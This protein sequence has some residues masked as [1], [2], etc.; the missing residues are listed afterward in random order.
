MLADPRPVVLVTQ[1]TIATD[2]R[3]LLQP[4]LHAL[5]DEPVQVIAV[6]GGPDPADLPAPPPN[7]RV[8][9]Y[10]P[11]AAL[12]P[13]VSAFVTNG[14]YGGLHFAL[15]HGVPIVV[16]G[17][18]EEKPELVA[19]VNWS[20]VGHR[21]AHAVSR[22]RSSCARRCGGCST[23]RASPDPRR[24]DAGR[25]GRLPR[26][27]PC[28]RA[29]RGPGRRQD[30]RADLIAVHEHVVERG[31]QADR[32]RAGQHRRVAEAR[33]LD[34]RRVRAVRG[35]Q[36]RGSAPAAGRR[37]APMPPPMTTSATSA[38]AAIGTM[39]AAIRRASSSTTARASS[40]PAR[41]APKIARTSYGGVSEVAAAP[42][43]RAARRS[44][45][46]ADRR[47]VV[48][49]LELAAERVV[50]LAGRAVVAAVQLAA[51]HEP[52]S[53]GRCRSTGTRSPP[54]PRRRRASAR[55]R[56]RG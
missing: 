38:T 42:R 53:R 46:D 10:V 50:D 33:D 32:Q 3:D 14:G 27:R 45:D 43:P 16:A 15:A 37:S 49:A 19:R 12:M 31:A 11:F 52:G 8:E 23:S 36:R 2:P 5:A 29:R 54:R 48:L 24:R 44:A 56:P 1:G 7:A 30:R 34:A 17:A 41:A 6:T 4:A 47:R 28:G 40:S 9:P 26:R 20:G 39:W 35:E 25:D 13:H 22:G 51:Q 21:H 18:S 55:R